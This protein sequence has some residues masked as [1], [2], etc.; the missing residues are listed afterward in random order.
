[1]QFGF[2]PQHSTTM[3]SIVYHKIINNYMSN[4]SNVYSCILDAIKAFDKV[5][6]GKL[7]IYY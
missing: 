2:K 6:Y 5:H 3:G 1:M 4:N 7:F